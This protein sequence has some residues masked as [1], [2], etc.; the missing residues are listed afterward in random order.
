VQ[1]IATNWGTFNF[2]TQT[3]LNVALLQLV[4]GNFPLQNTAHTFRNGQ[5]N[6]N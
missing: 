1:L 2:L 3:L 4:K 6:F 5:L